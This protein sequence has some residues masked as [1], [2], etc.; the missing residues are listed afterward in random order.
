MASSDPAE[1]EH[2]TNLSRVEHDKNITDKWQHSLQTVNRKKVSIKIKIKQNKR[3]IS[4]IEV[5]ISINVHLQFFFGGLSIILIYNNE[6]SKKK[7]Y[8]QESKQI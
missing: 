1:T 7:S 3:K 6:K 8:H 2:V 5:W 4:Q